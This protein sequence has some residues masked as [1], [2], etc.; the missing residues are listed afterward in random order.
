M[1]FLKTRK[2]VVSTV[3]KLTNEMNAD[4]NYVADTTEHFTCHICCNLHESSSSK[5]HHF[6]AG[7]IQAQKDYNWATGHI[8]SK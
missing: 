5:C 7:E 2:V 3:W 4:S 8:T 1:I 6:I